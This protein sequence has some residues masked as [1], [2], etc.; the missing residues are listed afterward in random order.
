MEVVE[1]CK[2]PC[3]AIKYWCHNIIW[4]SPRILHCELLI[5]LINWHDLAWTLVI[6][7]CIWSPSCF[8][9]FVHLQGG[10][11]LWEFNEPSLTTS[12][13]VQ[14][15]LRR[16]KCLYA[17][18]FLGAKKLAKPE[19]GDGSVYVLRKVFLKHIYLLGNQSPE[20]DDV[21]ARIVPSSA[22][23]EYVRKGRVRERW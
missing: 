2:F 23:S 13:F 9:S 15:K 17:R 18:D 4:S 21:L 14:G 6:S 16:T 1:D 8:R 3:L 5:F 7:S 12:I 19:V 11:D 10:A 20:T 22:W